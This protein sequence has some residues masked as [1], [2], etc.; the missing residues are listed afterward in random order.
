MFQASLL[1]QLKTRTRMVLCRMEDRPRLPLS[2]E[3]K[4]LLRLLS[5][6]C[7]LSS[8]CHLWTECLIEE[9]AFSV[10]TTT[11][12]GIA[13]PGLTA[14]TDITMSTTL[15]NSLG[16]RSVCHAFTLW[17]HD[18]SLISNTATTSTMQSQTVTASSNPGQNCTL[19]VCRCI[20]HCIHFSRLL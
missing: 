20:P 5:L 10:G 6:V 7:L 8:L 4:P 16:K 19:K 14:S 17:N 12:V 2:K 15:T 11:T 13:I 1:V 9:S 18:S 3:P